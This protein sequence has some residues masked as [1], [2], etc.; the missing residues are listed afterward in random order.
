MKS[1]TYFL[2]F[3][4]Y[5]T[6]EVFP[7]HTWWK[8]RGGTW[9]LGDCAPR[10]LV[11]LRFWGCISS[12]EALFVDYGRYP[13]LDAHKT[14]AVRVGKVLLGH[15]FRLVSKAGWFPI[16][17]GPSLPP[18]SLEISRGP[19]SSEGCSSL[20]VPG[21]T[22][23]H[24]MGAAGVGWGGGWEESILEPHNYLIISI[25]LDSYRCFPQ[26]ENNSV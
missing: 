6:R 21:K 19:N 10:F 1:D 9:A 25:H 20:L 22:L 8:P 24:L 16:V 11:Y 13:V 23:R 2:F 14:V 18:G 26:E 15:Q 12:G 17:V 5:P 3:K 4:N 7:F